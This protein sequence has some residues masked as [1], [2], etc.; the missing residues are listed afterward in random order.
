MENCFIFIII[1]NIYSIKD[2]MNIYM[3]EFLYISD[4]IH[5]LDNKEYRISIFD[6]Y[7]VECSIIHTEM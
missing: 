3:N 5:D 7:S 2:I 1:D 4:S 6:D